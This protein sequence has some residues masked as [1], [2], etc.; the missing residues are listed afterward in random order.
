MARRAATCS[1]SNAPQSMPSISRSSRRLLAR[2]WATVT[3]FGP[4]RF[5]RRHLRSGAATHSSTSPTRTS[6]KPR[7]RGWQR[8]DSPQ[9]RCALTLIS[10]SGRHAALVAELDRLVSDFPLRERFRANRWSRSRDRE[11]RPTRFGRTSRHERCS[12]TSSDSSRHTSCGCS[13]P[14]YCDRTSPSSPRRKQ[15]PRVCVR[16]SGHRS[17]R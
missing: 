5:S 8:R 1:P 13:R 12:P 14:R 11:G 10:R 17:H 2:Q 7:S 16:I 15:Y 9:S 3:R 6:R 4:V